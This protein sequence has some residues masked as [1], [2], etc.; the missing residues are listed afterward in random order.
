MLEQ[1]SI[2]RFIPW[3]GFSFV[4]VASG[5]CDASDSVFSRDADTRTDIS[6]PV[7]YDSDPADDVVEV[8]LVASEALVQIEPG[9]QVPMYTYNGVYPGP[10]IVADAGDRLVVHFHNDLPEP[11]TVH[12]HGVDVPANMDGSHISQGA[13]PPGGY[14]RYEFDLLNPSLHWFH[15][16]IRAKEQVEF[17]LQGTL[18]VRDPLEASLGLPDEEHILVLDDLLLDE[19]GLVAPAVPSDPLERAAVELNGREG[20]LLLVS[21]ERLPKLKVRSGQPV[22]LRLVNTSNARFWRLSFPGVAYRIG[23]DQGLLEHPIEL[24]QI[25]RIEHGGGPAGHGDDGGE[26]SGAST[27]VSDPDPNVGLLLTPGERADVV[28]VPRGQPGE[29]QFIAWHDLPRGRHSTSYRDDGT[30][31]IGHAHDDGRRDPIDVLELQFLGHGSKRSAGGDYAP[32]DPLRPA[33]PPEL[34]AVT[35]TL[36]AT[37]GHGAPDED[38][39]VTFFAQRGPSGPLPFDAVTPEDAQDVEVGQTWIWEVENLTGGMHNFHQHGWSFWPLETEY[40]DAMD[41]SGNWVVPHEHPEWKDTLLLP[42]RPGAMGSSKSVTRVAVYFG[43]EGREGRVAASGK[44]ASDGASGGWLFHCHLLEHSANGM[45][46]FFE[47]RDPE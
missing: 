38:G 44:V 41:P 19:E 23:G 10:T 1:F 18:L 34:D 46:S 4:C 21:G 22:R 16:H 43:D 6:P 36:K 39:H 30:I 29:R 5:G 2:G 26:H 37:F 24:S 31:G 7:A 3:V 25:E 28:F 27:L 32:P 8:V 15:P 45:M 42:A 11:T 40:V 12:W 9:L 47:V 14:H 35:G 17:G 33:E 13:V 20:N